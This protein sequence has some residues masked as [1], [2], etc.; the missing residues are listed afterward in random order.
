MNHSSNL[1]L[2]PDTGLPEILMSHPQ[3]MLFFEHFG[4]QVPLNG[5]T[6]AQICAEHDIRSELLISFANLYIGNEPPAD[7]GYKVSDIPVILKFLKTSHRYYL[8]EI[9]PEIQLL[10]QQMQNLNDTDEIRLVEKFF[11]EYF[12]EVKEHLDYENDVVFPY[13]TSLYE[14]VSGES[15]NTLFTTYSV[16]EYKKHHTNIEEKLDDLM[17][18]LISYLPLRRDQ[19][20]RR[21]L[22][23]NLVELNYD[24]NVHSRIED[25]V[26]VPLAEK[27]ERKLKG[28]S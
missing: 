27:M 17:N 18:L 5:K 19:R 8:D 2:T 16:I 25:L 3:A 12:S 14:H 20:V 4:I 15:S 13:I 1:L 7:K 6:V 22:F 21:K 11:D 26:L 9:Y 24:L 28:R 10:I 23:L